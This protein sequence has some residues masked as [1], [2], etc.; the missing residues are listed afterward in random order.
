MAS[1][2][3]TSPSRL[4]GVDNLWVCHRCEL[5]GSG[6]EAARHVDETGHPVDELT[7]EESATVRV[8]QDRREAE[9][10]VGLIAY[11]RFMRGRADA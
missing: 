11:A 4:P 5:I 9:R 8:E 10:V 2:S 6:F 1:E 7:A 3:E